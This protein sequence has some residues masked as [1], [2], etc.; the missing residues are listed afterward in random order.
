MSP[1]HAGTQLLQ[2]VDEYWD[3]EWLLLGTPVYWWVF[4]KPATI[5]V[6]RARANWPQFRLTLAGDVAVCSPCAREGMDML[7]SK[8]APE[9]II[10][11]IPEQ[12]QSVS[13]IGAYISTN[14]CD[15]SPIMPFF[16]PTVHDPPFP[17][18]Y[19]SNAPLSNVSCIRVFKN[20]TEGIC[21]GI[22]LEYKNGG[23][24]VHWAVSCRSWRGGLLQHAYTHMLPR[25]G[26]DWSRKF[27]HIQNNNHRVCQHTRPWTWWRLL[28]VFRDAGRIAI[29]VLLW[30]N[31]HKS[32]CPWPIL[33]PCHQYFCIS[34][35]RLPLLVLF[36]LQ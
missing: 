10:H 7:L 25:T 20:R 26:G 5:A 9:T 34:F 13:V 12:E 22:L 24:T 21:M 31:R 29:L 3:L 32:S 11:S 1:Y 27:L 30:R 16:H 36:R 17:K 28:D 8:S 18:A 19:F 4:W 23:Q 14:K 2:W 35:L 33:I 6:K 15:D